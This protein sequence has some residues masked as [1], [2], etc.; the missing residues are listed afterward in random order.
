MTPK[1]AIELARL[2]LLLLGRVQAIAPRYVD[3]DVGRC[4]RVLREH[5]DFWSEL[6]KR[7]PADRQTPESAF[8]SARI[9]QLKGGALEPDTLFDVALRAFELSSNA[10]QALPGDPTTFPPRP[11]PTP[12]QL[13]PRPT[14]ETGKG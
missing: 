6:A 4:S 10:M 11:G 5:S 7:L 14:T 13:R 8:I 2:F 9:R 12:P 3:T 1:D